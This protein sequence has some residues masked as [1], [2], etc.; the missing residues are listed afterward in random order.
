MYLLIEPAQ[1]L[2][3]SFFLCCP[4]Q[5]PCKIRQQNSIQSG[6]MIANAIITAIQEKLRVAAT[7]NLSRV[8][9]HELALV[10]RE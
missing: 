3:I 7:P 1:F 2:Q 9:Q 5:Y 8:N 4:A 6:D 10:F